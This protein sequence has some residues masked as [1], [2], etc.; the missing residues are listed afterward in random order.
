[1]IVAD[2]GG[3]H[4]IQFWTSKVESSLTTFLLRNFL[5]RPSLKA[6]MLYRL[7]N[8]EAKKLLP[9]SIR[10]GLARVA[11]QWFPISLILQRQVYSY[12]SSLS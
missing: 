2:L 4:V 12:L 3:T 11:S 9:V 5:G 7:N 10:R 6:S 1:M 8:V